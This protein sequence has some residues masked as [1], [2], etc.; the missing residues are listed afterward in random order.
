MERAAFQRAS[1]SITVKMD[2]CTSASCPQEKKKT[3]FA[4]IRI[5]TFTFCASS[6]TKCGL[7]LTTFSDIYETLFSAPLCVM[8]AGRV[9][10]AFENKTHFVLSA[11]STCLRFLQKYLKNVEDK[12]SWSTVLTLT[13][14]AK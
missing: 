5:F 7:F 1:Q 13:T 10:W 4:D 6:C 3:F 8:M 12:Q 11:F 2:D 9:F 14:A